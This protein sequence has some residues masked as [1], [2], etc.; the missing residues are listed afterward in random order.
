MS[1]RSVNEERLGASLEIL[2]SRVEA[3]FEAFAA[4]HE[5]PIGD[6]YLAASEVGE[7]LIQACRTLLNWELGRKLDCGRMDSRILAI[8]EKHGIEIK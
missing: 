2:V 8:A 5:S 3:M 7:P 6:D 4:A 1:T